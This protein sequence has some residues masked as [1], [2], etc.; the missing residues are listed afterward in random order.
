MEHLRFDLGGCAG[1]M[2]LEIHL[3]GS[4]ARVR[5]M[6]PVEYQVYLDGREY[7]Y[8]GG[9]FDVSPIVH[10]VPYD[11]DWYLVVDSYHGHIKVKCE[12]IFG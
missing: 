4:S 7:E 2:R 5:L 11:E 6:D 1:G 3:R 8:Y 10:E 12:E 9:Y